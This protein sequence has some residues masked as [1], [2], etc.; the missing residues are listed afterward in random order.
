VKFSR[1][2][3]DTSGWHVD[4]RIRKGLCSEFFERKAHELNLRWE[5]LYQAAPPRAR[6]VRLFQGDA[7][8]LVELLPQRTAAEL[9]MCSPPYGGTYDYARQH[10]LRNAWFGIDPSRWEADEIGARRHLSTGDTTQAAERWDDELGAFLR[11]ARR[12]LAPGGRIVL[13]LGD[14]ELSG[15]RVPADAQIASLAPDADLQLIASATQLRADPRSGHPRG[16]H[17]LLLQPATRAGK[18]Q[19]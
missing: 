9:I 7:R 15:Y 10:A 2:R 1:Q 18:R 17:L 11:S 3:A 8:H 5:A 13:W 16:E 19:E 4:K 6:P 14:A 12:M